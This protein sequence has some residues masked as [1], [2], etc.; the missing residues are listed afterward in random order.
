MCVCV[1][2]GG[3]GGGARCVKARIHTTVHSG[4][5]K[6]LLNSND[7]PV[8]VLPTHRTASRQSHN[9]ELKNTRIKEQNL[10]N[11]IVCDK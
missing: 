6:Y 10:G 7:A 2:G 1:W 9:T 4:F 3:G 5:L 8:P 11:T